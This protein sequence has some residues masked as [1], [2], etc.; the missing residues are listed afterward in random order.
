MMNER[1]SIRYRKVDL[2]KL[3][4]LFE[5]PAV[6]QIPATGLAT[7]VAS[8][9]FSK[10]ELCFARSLKAGVGLTTTFKARFYLTFQNQQI[11]NYPNHFKVVPFF[12]F[13]P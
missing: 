12:Y 5:I 11:L 6:I 3:V 7:K 8:R 4:I 9:R 2:R 13:Y 10:S 1:R